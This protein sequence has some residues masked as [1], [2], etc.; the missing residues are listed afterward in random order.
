MTLHN[1]IGI[2]QEEI[3]AE[4]VTK[5][6]KEDSIVG[7]KIGCIILQIKIGSIIILIK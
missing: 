7:I 3:E 1:Q 5:V 2:L 6:V 4:A